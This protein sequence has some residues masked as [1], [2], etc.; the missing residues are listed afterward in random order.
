MLQQH[1]GQVNQH[2]FA[3][4]VEQGKE[5]MQAKGVA[6]APAFQVEKSDPIQIMDGEVDDYY[7]WQDDKYGD[8]YNHETDWEV[9][10]TNYLRTTPITRYKGQKR[11]INQDYLD[12]QKYQGWV[13]DAKKGYGKYV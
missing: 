10:G 9:K 5:S 11:P 8:Q 1:M 3:S 2:L 13:D 4:L 12:A 7:V 6:E